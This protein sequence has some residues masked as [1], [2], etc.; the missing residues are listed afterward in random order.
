M[1]GVFGGTFDP[2]HNGH[3]ALLEAAE[4]AFAFA[5][6]LVL[7][8]ADPGHREVHAP[9]DQR[10]ALAR[11]AFPKH[12]VELD[13]HPRTID[14]LRA[15]RLDDPVLLIGADELAAFPTWKEPGALLELARLAV[16]NRPGYDVSNDSAP[17]R[18][19]SFAMEPSDVSATEVRRRVAAAEPID[20]LVPPAV[21]AGI[22]RL[23]LYRTL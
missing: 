10:L 1:V 16:V 17:G 18:V 23:G 2:P 4:E 8:V 6:V 7:V 12:E 9:A 20:D 11:L 5:G 14:M 15:R 22:A 19:L 3:V 13:G 21:A